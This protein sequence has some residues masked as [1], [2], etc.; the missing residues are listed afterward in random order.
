MTQ[1]WKSSTPV[2]ETNGT[3]TSDDIIITDLL[4]GTNPSRST[5]R[6]ARTSKITKRCIGIERVDAE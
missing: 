6:S 1:S 2:A 3:V 4:G 5:T